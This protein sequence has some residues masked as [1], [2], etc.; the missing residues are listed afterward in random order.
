[1]VRVSLEEAIDILAYLAVTAD[2]TVTAEEEVKARAIAERHPRLGPAAVD[3]ARHKHVQGLEAKHGRDELTEA[4][5]AAV[6]RDERERV[7][8]G[9]AEITMCD[10]PANDDEDDFLDDV[11]FRMELDD[12][13]IDG[14]YQ[15]ARQ[16]VGLARA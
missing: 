11:A 6:P 13:S 15:K 10:G 3:R 16:A 8:E 7:W 14:L 2:G 9:L 1:M 5:C 12:E 4:A